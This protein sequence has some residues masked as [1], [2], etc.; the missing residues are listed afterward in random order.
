MLKDQTHRSRSQF[1][2]NQS[3]IYGTVGFHRMGQCIHPGSCGERRRH[4]H[5]QFIIIHSQNGKHIPVGISIFPVLRFIDYYIVAGTFAPR[6]RRCRNRNQRVCSAAFICPCIVLNF[7]AARRCHG[8]CLSAVVSRTAADGNEKIALI[9]Y[10]CIR[11]LIYI[12]C[13]RVWL[14]ISK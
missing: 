13:C 14:K 12:V 5:H 11:A 2:C 10:K 7:S 6:S 8:N 1:R 9:S 3:S 4:I